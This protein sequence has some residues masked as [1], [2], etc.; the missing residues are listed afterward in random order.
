MGEEQH[1]FL[2]DQR[3]ERNLYCTEFI[4]RKWKMRM[5]QRQKKE[6]GLTKMLQQEAETIK[7]LD[8]IE[9]TD[10]LAGALDLPL[11]DNTE[12]EDDEYHCHKGHHLG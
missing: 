10:Q 3:A 1:I 2:L 11:E 6:D 12:Q 8:S 4:D 7:K 9:F 5:L